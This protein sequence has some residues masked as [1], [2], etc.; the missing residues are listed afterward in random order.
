MKDKHKLRKGNTLYP[1]DIVKDSFSAKKL[2]KK[3]KTLEPLEAEGSVKLGLGGVISFGR[4]QEQAAVGL[5][6]LDVENL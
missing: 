6:Y 3:F 1:I 4:Q 5:W 2:L